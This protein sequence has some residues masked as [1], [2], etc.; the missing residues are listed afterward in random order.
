MG[1]KEDMCY[2]R[3]E[4]VIESRLVLFFCIGLV[5]EVARDSIESI[6]KDS[7]LKPVQ[8]RITLNTQL[9]F[10]RRIVYRIQWCQC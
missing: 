4:R 10:C 2:R 7:E 1:L 6:T 3:Q 9:L 8:S 5:E